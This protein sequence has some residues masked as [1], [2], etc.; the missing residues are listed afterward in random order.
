M[1]TL[2]LVLQL[3]GSLENSRVCFAI[4]GLSWEHWGLLCNCWALLRIVGLVLQL[5]GSLGNSGACFAFAGLLGTLGL[6][7][8]LLGSLGNSGACYEI[9]GLSWEL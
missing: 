7:L 1:V 6:V 4:A 9:A 8:Q 5:L 2:G 3:L